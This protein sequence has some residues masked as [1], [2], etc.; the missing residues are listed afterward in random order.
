MLPRGAILLVQS[1]VYAM[2]VQ[3]DLGVWDIHYR[4]CPAESES[5]HQG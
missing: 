1:H 3:S 5:G 2:L 4:I